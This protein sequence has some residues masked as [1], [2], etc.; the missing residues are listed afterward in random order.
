MKDDHRDVVLHVL[1]MPTTGFL[2]KRR[3]KILDRMERRARNELGLDSNEA[4]DWSAIDWAA[5]FSIL[6]KLLMMFFGL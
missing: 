5:I 2:G 1:G 6:L 4:I 3:E